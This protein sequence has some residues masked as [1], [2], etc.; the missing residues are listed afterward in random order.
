MLEIM[1]AMAEPRRLLILR[2]VRNSEMSAGEIARQFKGITRPAVSQ[3]LTILKK[4]GL[5]S[6]RREGTSRFYCLRPEGFASIKTLLEDFWNPR[7]DK[8]KAAAE[9]EERKRRE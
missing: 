6:E 4:A 7:L 1:Q 9:K 8:L 2:M 3:H 5:I